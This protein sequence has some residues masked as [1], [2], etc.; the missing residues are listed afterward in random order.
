MMHTMRR[1]DQPTNRT[2]FESSDSTDDIDHQLSSCLPPSHLPLHSPPHK[3][4][5][6]GTPPTFRKKNPTRRKKRSIDILSPER[7]LPL[8][9]LSPAHR[10]PSGKLNH[11]TPE[12]MS[13][14]KHLNRPSSERFVPTNLKL[15]EMDGGDPSL[16]REAGAKSDDSL[17]PPITPGGSLSPAVNQLIKSLQKTPTRMTHRRTGSGGGP[18]INLLQPP[19]S[20][21][22]IMTNTSA[23]AIATAGPI[24]DSISTMEHSGCKVDGKLITNKIPYSKLDS[25]DS[26]SDPE[27]VTTMFQEQ[28]N[29]NYSTSVLTLALLRSHQDRK[30]NTQLLSETGHAQQVQSSATPTDQHHQSEDLMVSES[31][32]RR[33][34]AYTMLSNESSCEV[35]GTDGGHDADSESD[36][37]ETESTDHYPTTTE[38][39]TTHTLTLSISPTPTFSTSSPH[40]PSST[41]SDRC[42]TSPLSSLGSPS[43]QDFPTSPT[44]TLTTNTPREITPTAAD[45]RE[46][47]EEEASDSSSGPEHQSVSVSEDVNSSISSVA[48][49][50]PGQ[51]AMLIS[52]FEEGINEPVDDDELVTIAT[53]THSVVNNPPDTPRLQIPL[54]IQRKHNHIRRHRNQSS[55]SYSPI[56]VEQA[57]SLAIHDGSLGNSTSIVRHFFENIVSKGLPEEVGLN[58]SYSTTELEDSGFQVG[59]I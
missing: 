45:D 16:T 3:Q 2:I 27:T 14:G 23:T 25:S 15:S 21:S 49:S 12:E 43:H 20:D 22:G 41:T 32:P 48:S 7:E 6:F 53:D 35:T 13:G 8:Q 56:K 18:M 34:G 26:D 28:D 55:G 42:N 57:L 40:P 37:S 47:E 24:E 52:Q 38:T 46:E 33:W 11:R 4:V 31:N 51:V 59:N 44:E 17:E 1:C 36:C 10:P 29:S 58:R 5:T 39:T 54:H 19:P 50:Q 9:I 30:E